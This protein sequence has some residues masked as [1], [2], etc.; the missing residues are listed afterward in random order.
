MPKAESKEPVNEKKPFFGSLTGS[1]STG[2]GLFGSA[3]DKPAAD[4]PSLFPPKQGGLFT[5]IVTQPATKDKDGKEP[6]KPTG[7]LF[8]FGSTATSTTTAPG[9][10]IF[11]ASNKPPGSLFGAA[12][13][14]TKSV[15]GNTGNLFSKPPSATVEAK[16]DED[17]K[18]E[19]GAKS[20][21]CYATE[22]DKVEFKGQV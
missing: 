6:P 2:S 11:S 8:N 3:A 15:F 20:P 16:E 13:P 7:G 17:E 12:V 22:N 19:E 10:G 4:K 5:G 18:E 1:I 21:P 14:G 9:A